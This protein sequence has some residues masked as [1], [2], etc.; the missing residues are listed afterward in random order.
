[1]RLLSVTGLL[2]ILRNRWLARL[3]GRRA[4]WMLMC[5]LKE[6]YEA[7]IPLLLGELITSRS[8]RYSDLILQRIRGLPDDVR[9]SNEF[10]RRHFIT[11]SLRASS[12]LEG[13][14]ICQNALMLC[15]LASPR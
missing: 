14:T 6:N 15:F 13:A 8:V 5:R 9:E 1:M 7:Y 11:E 2:R 12:V 3:F 4:E 10:L